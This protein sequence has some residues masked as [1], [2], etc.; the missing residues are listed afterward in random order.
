MTGIACAIVLLFL[1]PQTFG[2]VE[3]RF[4][5]K[6]DFS[7]YRTYA[8][9]KGHEAYDPAAHKTIVAAIDGQM[10]A[11][12]LKKAETGAADVSVT[13][14]TVRSSDVDLKVFEKLYKEGRDTATATKTSG[15]LAV[16]LINPKSGATVWTALTRRRLSDDPAKW[17]DD[18]RLAVA[19][20]FETYPGR[21]S[22][23]G[24]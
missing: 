20:L 16:V 6:A 4:D 3:S 10:A 13:Y 12:G 21:K 19:S 14:D 17:S 11:V 24:H 15:R 5:D 23:N 8:W 1:M 2:E 18:L 22:K 7:A 9:G